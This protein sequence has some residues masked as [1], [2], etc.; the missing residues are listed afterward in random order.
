MESSPFFKRS[1]Y[2]LDTLRQEFQNDTF[3]MLGYGTQGRGQAL[4]LRDNGKTPNFE[5]SQKK[6]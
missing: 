3:S 2:P 6:K 4:N 5:F 1:D